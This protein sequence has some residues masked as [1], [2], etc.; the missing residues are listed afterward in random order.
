MPGYANA[1]FGAPAGM[2]AAEEYNAQRLDNLYRLGQIAQQPGQQRLTEARAANEELKY[3]EEKNLQD[4][5][6]RMASDPGIGGEKP[7]SLADMYEKLAV[8]AGPVAPS[9]AQ[10]L[11][12]TAAT[13]RYRQVAT[14]RQQSL[15]VSDGLKAAQTRADLMGRLMEGVNDDASWNRALLLYQVQTG[16]PSIYAGL[17]YSKAMRDRLL[18]ESMSVKDQAAAADRATEYAS[19]ERARKS[20]EDYRATLLKLQKDRNA[21]AARREERMAKH[22][23]GKGVSAPAKGETDQA[24]RLISKDFPDLPPSDVLNAAYEVASEA[25]VMRQKNPALDADTALNKAYLD[26]RFRGEFKVAKDAAALKNLYMPS[27]KTSFDSGKTPDRALALPM[28]NGKVDPTKL[29]QGRYYRSAKGVGMWTG[30]GFEL[31]GSS[32]TLS[33]DNG[34]TESDPDLEA[35]EQAAA[36]EKE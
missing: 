1:L 26:A 8:M 18:N 15:M 11:A 5:F 35:Q 13:L 14:E 6:A 9:Q 21:I 24:A 17:P 4:V 36:Q 34:D 20:L 27:K 2:M 33:S 28:A 31:V 25:R 16:Q 22:G 7:T 12:T 29:V 32:A 23:A 19:R 30:T 10:K 3:S